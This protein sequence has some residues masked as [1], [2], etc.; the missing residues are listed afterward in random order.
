M[1]TCAI[2]NGHVARADLSVAGSEVFHKWCVRAEGTSRS[3]LNKAK[4]D[5][6]AADMLRH[7]AAVEAQQVLERRD[8]LIRNLTEE[9]REL[10]T[11][12]HRQERELATQKVTVIAQASRLSEANAEC[13]RIER[14]LAEAFRLRD[15]A[16]KEAAFHQT[17]QRAGPVSPHRENVATSTVVDERDPTVVRMSLL[18]LDLDK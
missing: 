12:I 18:D 17:I 8:A 7:Q 1:A 6:L 9:N 5:A 2:C 4:A 11:I 10:R 13:D 3:L 15:A 14:E 16:I